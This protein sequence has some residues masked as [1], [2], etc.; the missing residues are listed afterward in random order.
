MSGAVSSEGLKLPYNRKSAHIFNFRQLSRTC[1]I[2]P[3]LNLL[4]LFTLKLNLFNYC[5]SQF[6]TLYLL[7]HK[8]RVACSFVGRFAVGNPY[9]RLFYLCVILLVHR[10]GL[11]SLELLFQSVI[12]LKPCLT[13]LSRNRR[14]YNHES[15][16]GVGQGNLTNRPERLCKIGAYPKIGKRWRSYLIIIVH[17]FAQQL[18][19]F[20]PVELS[21]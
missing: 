4:Q 17:L 12:C 8:L 6:K 2:Y 20:A 19:F 14:R 9:K 18:D 5:Q 3:P 7:N 13:C 21:L 16:V 1:F 10:F 15:L 11:L